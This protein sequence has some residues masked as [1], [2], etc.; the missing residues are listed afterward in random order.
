MEFTFNKS[1]LEFYFTN[2]SLGTHGEMFFDWKVI[3]SNDKGK[4]HRNADYKPNLGKIYCDFKVGNK[5]YSGVNV[6]EDINKKMKETYDSLL[7]KRKE[8]FK[9]VKLKLVS[10][11]IPVSFSIVGCD[12]PYYGVRIDSKY[13]TDDLINLKYELLDTAIRTLIDNKYYPGASFEF[14]ENRLKQ[15]IC[16]KEKINKQAFNIQYDS[17]CQYYHGYDSNIVT[18]FDMKLSDAIR[19]KDF[20]KEQTEKEEKINKEKERINTLRQKAAETGEK[21]LYNQHTENCND[22]KE[23]CNIDIVSTYIMPDGSF[24]T[25]RQH[26]W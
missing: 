20:I 16:T 5:K 11:E 15:P 17:K 8:R 4:M 13:L 26:T 6:P 2:P 14:I 19:L 24:K 7:S 22:P 9:N 12:Y 25:F 10:G 21:Q 23:E 3:G 18:D 1:G